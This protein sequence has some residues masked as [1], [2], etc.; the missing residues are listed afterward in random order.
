MI[1]TTPL[2]P[3][4]TGYPPMG[5]LSVINYLRKNGVDDVELYNIDSNRPSYEE[6]LAHIIAAK[7]RVF[8]ISAVVST[9]YAYTKQLSLDVKAALPET[10]IVVGGNLA[11]SAEI[12]LRKT[13]TDLCVL[14]EGEKTF[15]KIVRQSERASAIHEYKNIPGLALIDANDELINT[16]YEAPL[17][18]QEIYD[19][20]WR[21]LEESS[22]ISRYIYDPYEADQALTW[23]LNDPR[24]H[25]PHRKNKKVV[26][27]HAAKGCVARCT[28]CHRFEKGV[29]YIPVDVLCQRIKE[30][31][32]DYDIGY[33][34]V[35]DENFGT[36]RRWLAAFCKMINSD[37]A[38]ALRSALCNR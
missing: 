30:L 27:L 33:L 38:P 23:L 31:V 29:R 2:R 7:P 3:V 14:G 11:A 28:F 20:D 1:V 12:L 13:G 10:L 22:D 6:A 24:A 8:G 18:S 26:E 25:Q 17:S 35:A 15:L 21:D 32:D 16:G 4:P 9:A 37:D 36:D 34:V 19:V 5:S